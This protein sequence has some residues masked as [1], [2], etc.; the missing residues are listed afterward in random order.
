MFSRHQAK[1][2]TPE[3]SKALNLA[4]PQE[5]AAFNVADEDKPDRR[6][7][8]LCF[9]LGDELH[10][11]I[12]ELRKPSYQGEQQPYQ[13][14]VSRWELVP[15]DKQRSYASRSGGKGL[16]TNWIVTQLR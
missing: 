4:L 6:T 5:V 15:G 9:V 1:L 8:G 3:L 2:L 12:E 7:K 13:Q 16:A 14:Q 11:I 10:L